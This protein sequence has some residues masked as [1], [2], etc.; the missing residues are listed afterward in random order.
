MEQLQTLGI[1]WG[2]DEA[3]RY[4]DLVSAVAAHR[5]GPGKPS[6]ALGGYSHNVQGDMQ[7][8]AEFLA[9][10][11]SRGGPNEALTSLSIR[12]HPIHAGGSCFYNWTQT[13]RTR[14]GVTRAC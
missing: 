1:A 8:K 3:F 7:R 2:A 13:M 10:D 9:A 12:G 5:A 11:S 4:F 14:C 6:H